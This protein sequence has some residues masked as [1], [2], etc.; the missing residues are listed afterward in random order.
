MGLGDL[1]S[2]MVSVKEMSGPVGIV[3]TIVD[4]GRSSASVAD[5][6]LNVAYL[7]AFIAINLAVMNMLPLPALD[8]GRIFLLLVGAVFTA[9]T[10]KKIP[11]KYEG[12]IHAVGMILLL[13]FMAL[14]TFKDV[15]TLFKT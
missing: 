1:L 11:S 3:S 2:G 12:Y 5:G 6:L 14:V 13:A 15:W 7:G 9:I 10:K 8:G 4:T